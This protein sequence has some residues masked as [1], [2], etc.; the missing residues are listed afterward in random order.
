MRRE[1]GLTGGAVHSVEACSAVEERAAVGWVAVA[2]SGRAAL[3]HECSLVSPALHLWPQKIVYTD[4]VY[5]KCQASP[6]KWPIS[7]RG[8]RERITMAMQG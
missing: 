8:A 4:I 6:L 1:W 7:L 3:G 5:I 2:L